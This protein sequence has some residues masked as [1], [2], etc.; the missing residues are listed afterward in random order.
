[1]RAARKKSNLILTFSVFEQLEGDEHRAIVQ[2][3]KCEVY[4]RRYDH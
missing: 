1:M 2:S 4:L 3:E